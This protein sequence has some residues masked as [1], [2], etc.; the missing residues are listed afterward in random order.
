VHYGL[1]NYIVTPTDEPCPPIHVATTGCVTTTFS[2]SKW[3][4]T[5][6]GGVSFVLSSE[7]SWLDA[8]KQHMEVCRRHGHAVQTAHTAS[9][10]FDRPAAWDWYDQRGRRWVVG[11]MTSPY[12]MNALTFVRRRIAEVGVEAS[13]GLRE[14]ASDV[15]VCRHMTLLLTARARGLI[16]ADRFITEVADYDDVALCA[17]AAGFAFSPK[18][19][20]VVSDEVSDTSS[21]IVLPGE[22]T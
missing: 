18:I 9:C 10:V 3:V 1:T 11:D 8:C 2:M 14:P 5:S 19:E 6:P 16:S 20:S 15:W 7:A 22:E 13:A 21:N 12:L 4:T 17:A